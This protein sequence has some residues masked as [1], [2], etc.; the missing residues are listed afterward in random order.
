MKNNDL[1]QVVFTEEELT[2]NKTH[3]D[4]LL[5]TATKNAPELSSE[6][7]TR[8]GKIGGTNKLLVDKAH[9]FMQ[10]NPSLI[11]AFVNMEEFARDFKAREEIEG[12]IQKLELITRRL[13]DTKILL[14]NDNYNDA[15]AF[16]RAIRYYAGEQEQMAIPIYEEM[17][18]F[19]PHGKKKEE[20]KAE[21]ENK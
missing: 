4:E 13:S 1:I 2:A 18:Q 10:Q 16:Y 9:L 5:T 7:R 14:D 11:P 3:L 21:T 19:F 15:M 12:M 17:K 20:E 8:Y 6:E